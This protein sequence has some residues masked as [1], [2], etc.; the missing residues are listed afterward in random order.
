MAV[1]HSKLV[2]NLGTCTVFRYAPASEEAVSEYLG[3]KSR[4]EFIITPVRLA[5]P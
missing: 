1:L 5:Y 3:T 2:H 4:L